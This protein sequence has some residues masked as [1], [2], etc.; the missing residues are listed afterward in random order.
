VLPITRVSYTQQPGGGSDDLL[1][2]LGGAGAG[3][4]LQCSW[5]S[6]A[7]A[8]AAAA[9][10]ASS[11][12]SGAVTALG[13]SWSG[14]FRLTGTADGRVVVEAGSCSD[15]ARATRTWEGSLHDAGHGAVRGLAL[16]FDD[17]CLLSGAADGTLLL[18]ANP[19]Q[20]P[21]R[22]AAG[23]A[24]AAVNAGLP[25]LAAAAAAA[26]AA[27]DGAPQGA[28]T[29]E[30]PE[31]GGLTLEEAKRAAQR[32]Q[33]AATASAARQGLV[34]AVAALRDELAAL[35]AHNA[36]QPLAA[37]VPQEALQLDAGACCQWC[38]LACV[39]V[40]LWRS[41]VAAAVA[42]NLVG[43]AAAHTHTP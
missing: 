30:L 32:D 17:S 14:R 13:S 19:L 1:L 29:S 12:A 21:G 3:Q 8:Y 23:E 38:V 33:Q 20:Q 42:D 27:G 28:Q 7:A 15:C 25:T 39:S 35:L 26:A 34:A 10:T 31:G 4:V 40:R 16:A 6:G 22:P 5:A 9:S 18:L 37:Q 41:W 36:A 43:V 24:G 11:S 2:W